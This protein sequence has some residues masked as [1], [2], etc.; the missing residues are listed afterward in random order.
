MLPQSNRVCLAE[1]GF[2]VL[3]VGRLGVWEFLTVSQI[4]NCPN[5]GLEISTGCVKRSKTPNDDKD[6]QIRFEIKK[7]SGVERS[8]CGASVAILYL[9]GTK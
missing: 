2:G 1:Q 9:R 6:E 3:E 8:L 5:L 7:H 4:A